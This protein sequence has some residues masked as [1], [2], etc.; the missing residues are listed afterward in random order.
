MS[1]HLLSLSSLLALGVFGISLSPAIASTPQNTSLNH[2]VRGSYEISQLNLP[3]P[4]GGN[5]SSTAG[6]GKRGNCINRETRALFVP[7]MA[8]ASANTVSSAPSLWWNLPPN[9][10]AQ[11]E[12]SIFKQTGNTDSLVH[13]QVI[14][15]INGKS[16]LL[17]IDLPENTLAAGSSY[18]WDLTLACD[19]VDRSGDIYLWGS[20]ERVDPSNVSILKSEEAVQALATTLLGT[21]SYLTLEPNEAQELGSALQNNPTAATLST[22]ETRLRS[23]YIGLQN[24]YAKLSQ[25]IRKLQQNPSMNFSELDMLKRQRGSMVLE[26]AQ[27]SA[28]FNV[29]GDAVDL[30][31]T[32]R[33]KH[34]DEWKSLVETIFPE[35]NLSSEVEEGQIIRALATAPN[36]FLN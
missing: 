23:H 31:A 24:D 27:L 7:V 6:G 18:W 11:L 32:Y 2:P 19:V 8:N 33:T 29:W 9:K 17:E 4:S 35:D 1:K 14:N 13:Y 26:L 30:L 12:L 36:F 5:P 16:G 22:V 25:S 10:A 15:N 20:I 3:A 34:P 28:Y 21:N